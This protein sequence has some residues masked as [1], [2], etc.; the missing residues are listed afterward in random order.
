MK[1]SRT[2]P[3]TLLVA[4]LAALLAL[5]TLQAPVVAATS[6]SKTQAKTKV[7]ITLTKPK[8]G[9][10]TTAGSS[11]TFS[12]KVKPFTSGAVVTVQ[13]QVGKKW[14][15]ISGSTKLTSKGTFSHGFTI[16]DSAI[17]RAHVAAAGSKAAASSLSTS[18]VANPKIATTS[19]PSGSKGTAYA[20]TVKQVGTNPGTW[21][22]S[23]ALPKS[24]KL[25]KTSGAITGTPTGTSSAS[26]T[27]KF[28][29]P[30]VKTASK[31]LSLTIAAP[32]PPV[33][34]TS[35]LYTGQTRTPYKKTLT[36][37]GKPAGTWTASPLPPGL[38]VNSSTGVISGTPTTAGVTNVR[39]G[40]TQASTGLSTARALNLTI[41][42]PP[43]PVITTTELLDGKSRVAY[44]YRLR[45]E[46][47]VAGVWTA[48]GLPSGLT[49]NPTTGV[50]SGTP[51][52]NLFTVTYS[53]TIGFT[54]NSTGVAATPVGPLP[55]KISGLLL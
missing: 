44:T 55:L 48:S 14:S 54:Q 31:K 26:Y 39:I 42:S 7:T 10:T 3:V 16:K 1:F 12:G 5:G 24:L 37:A 20:G 28:A 11:V 47:N 2:L 41:V 23:P 53:V 30:G 29:Q 33:I 17:Y 18:V 25:N 49:L 45:V 43:A 36:A 32:K 13:R 35:R 52:S 50:I 4:V 38:T 34:T 40:F 22:V 51:G 15:T 6:V 8:A 9:T 21:T 27:F 19:L 46:D